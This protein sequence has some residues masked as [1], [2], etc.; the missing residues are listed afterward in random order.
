MDWSKCAA[1][2]DGCN[3]IACAA[4]GD[5]IDKV[6][7]NDGV[8]Y[9]TRCHL[10]KATCLSGVQM[11]HV[12]ACNDLAIPTKKGRADDGEACPKECE[13]E[14]GAFVCG[15]D[16]NAYEYEKLFKIDLQYQL[17]IHRFG[18][19]IVLYYL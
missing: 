9:D 11:A 4:S 12:G 8:T 7:G 1:K 6:C 5:D 3:A 13:P 15:S 18:K 16:G 19:F 2:A 10:T 14:D 17:R